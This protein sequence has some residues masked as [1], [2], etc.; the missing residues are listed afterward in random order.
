[1]MPEAL[2]PYAPPKA[3]LDPSFTEDLWRDGKILV[4]RN[5]SHLP[6]RC[7]K[8]NGPAVTPMKRRKVYWHHPAL[9]ALLVSWPIYLI[10][11]LIVR[12]S[13]AVA[14]GLCSVHRT[15]RWIGIAVGWG[16]LLLSILLMIVG[17]GS[18]NGLLVLAGLILFLTA[19]V[20]AV[21]LSRLIFPQ[22]IDQDF[23]RLKGCGKAFL[24]SLPEFRG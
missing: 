19:L 16:G 20:A 13:A 21:L 7:I 11:A 22:R 6:D 8:C 10:V 3:S 12:K 5:G 24:D 9:Y 18:E 23:V 14:P 15:R 1:M 4:L 2:N 17:G